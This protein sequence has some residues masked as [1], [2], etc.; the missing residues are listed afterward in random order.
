M[1]IKALDFANY[2]RL[3]SGANG[4]T[5]AV[6]AIELSRNMSAMKIFSATILSRRHA[7]DSGRCLMPFLR[8]KRHGPCAL[9]HP[10]EPCVGRDRANILPRDKASYRAGSVARGLFDVEAPIEAPDRHNLRHALR[11]L[12]AYVTLGD[13]SCSSE[14]ARGRNGRSLQESQSTPFPFRPTA[15]LLPRILYKPGP[16]RRVAFPALHSYLHHRP[17]FP[18]TLPSHISTP[19]QHR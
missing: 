2:P 3:S 18:R 14:E 8:E 19:A 11:H 16:R 13:T 6:V 4:C 9:E 15:R 12:S 17:F 1:S 7:G 5:G 10:A